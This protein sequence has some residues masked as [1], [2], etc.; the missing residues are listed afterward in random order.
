[1]SLTIRDIIYIIIVGRNTFVMPIVDLKI[2]E[3]S[4]PLIKIHRMIP[5]FILE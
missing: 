2:M 3:D 4:C 5:M 1:M